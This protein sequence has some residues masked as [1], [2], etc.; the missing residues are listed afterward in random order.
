MAEAPVIGGVIASVRQL[1][2]GDGARI[3]PGSKVDWWPCARRL[4]STFHRC[5]HRY[6]SGYNGYYHT[7]A[8]IAQVTTILSQSKIGSIT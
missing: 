5:N 7:F 4:T 3:A 8:Y 2:Q 1:G 6:R